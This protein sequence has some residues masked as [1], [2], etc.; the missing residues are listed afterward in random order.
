MDSVNFGNDEA[1]RPAP[2][3]AR[4]PILVGYA[5]VAATFFGL[6]GWASVAQIDSAVVTQGNIAVESNRRTIQH[7]E[8]GIVSEIFV[9]EGA[10]VEAGDLL[11]RLD[12]TRPRAQTAILQI[13]LESQL[14]IMARLTAEREGRA[15]VVF[16]A[17]LLAKGNDP[18]VREVLATQVA[19]FEARMAALLGQ[20]SILEQR[21]QQFNE[22]VVGLRALERSKR[23]QRQLIEEE[24]NSLS[25]LL[26][27]AIVTRS[28]V[29]ALQREASRL[30]GE[31]GEHVSAIARAQQGAGEA[32]LQILQL[33]KARQDEIAQQF[34]DAQS[35][36]FQ[37][38]EQLV[39]AEDSLRRIDVVA[40]IS[41][42]VLNM[43]LFTEGG[44][45]APGAPIMYIVPANDELI[46]ETQIAPTEIDTVKSGT[47][48]T[49]R[50][51]TSGS[52]LLP[53]IQGVLDVLSPDR[54]SDTRTGIAF[55][56]ARVRIPAEELRRLDGKMKLHAGMPVEVLIKRGERTL[57][58]YLVQPLTNSLAKA[59]REV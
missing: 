46:V 28:R 4:R 10:A 35:R 6:G 27:Q 14:A 34:R 19:I 52:R 58:E 53:T 54:I 2:R 57:L 11:L 21:V 40:P 39:A 26:D 42:T 8:G 24:L 32:R 17:E 25:G 12:P 23:A 18:N 20:R 29:L 22:Q 47:E 49:I 37:V 15:R 16:P 9:K 36:S 3:N 48:V 38:R 51:S 56:T 50:F 13:E 43:S 59:F 5:L 30:D 1:M 44:V 41:G 45:L 7:L 31:I 33:E 55:Y